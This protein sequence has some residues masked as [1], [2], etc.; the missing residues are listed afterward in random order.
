M[1]ITPFAAFQGV[2]SDP[3]HSPSTTAPDGGE[4]GLPYEVSTHKPYPE[5]NNGEW[6]SAD[7]SNRPDPAV[8]GQ[9]GNDIGL[10]W[11]T[12]LRPRRERR[13]RFDGRTLVVAAGQAANP[14][15]GAVGRDNR[16]DD[17]SARVRSQ[18]TNFLPPVDVIAASFTGMRHS[19]PITREMS[20]GG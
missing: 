2:E 20:D 19:S 18:D 5:D 13:P 4:Y 16:A 3:A 1:R 10:G 7:I 14:N 12:G 17:L 11:T 6:G 9:P 15:V 8:G